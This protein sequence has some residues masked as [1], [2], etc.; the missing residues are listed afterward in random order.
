MDLDS[1]Y[2]EII[3]DHYKNPHHKGLREPFEAEVHHVNPTCG[4][5]VTLRVHLSEGVVQD[6]SYDALGCSISQAAASVMTDLVIGKPV[7]EAMR[8]HGEFLA[9]MQGKGT[10]EPDEEVLEDGIAFAGVA[11]FPAR[12]KCALLSW[13]AWKDATTRS[14]EASHG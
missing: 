2:Q 7:D 5:E 11:K 3:L 12:V 10:V 9:L 6:V 13:M 14:L 1:L 4:D 8:I